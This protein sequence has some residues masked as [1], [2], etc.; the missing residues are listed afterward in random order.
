MVDTRKDNH[1]ENSKNYAYE[2]CEVLF[3][4]R[5]DEKVMTRIAEEQDSIDGQRA[6]RTTQFWLMILSASCKHFV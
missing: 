4:R 1:R 5:G 6:G 2:V 3:A